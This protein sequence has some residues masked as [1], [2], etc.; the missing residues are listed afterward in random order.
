MCR[1]YL[2]NRCYS[3]CMLSTL[4]FRNCVIAIKLCRRRKPLESS[5][6]RVLTK[7]MG[8]VSY[9]SMALGNNDLDTALTSEL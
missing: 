6:K 7:A 4:V 9:V 5:A 3:Y 1:E 8:I 2:Y